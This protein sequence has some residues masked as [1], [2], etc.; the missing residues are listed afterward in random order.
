MS[1]IPDGSEVTMPL[2]PRGPLPFLKR[3]PSRIERIFP[4]GARRS[5]VPQLPSSPVVAQVAAGDGALVPQAPSAPSVTHTGIATERELPRV[6]RSVWGPTVE[7]VKVARP[8]VPVV[9]LAPPPATVTPAAGSAVPDPGRTPRYWVTV[10]VN[11]VPGATVE[12]T[13]P[14]TIGNTVGLKLASEKSTSIRSSSP[15][16]S[17][18]LQMPL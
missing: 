17:A 3:C 6:A 7:R 2:S 1:P 18:S 10:T 13:P 11:A 12:G 5:L 15:S 4:R 9:A 16:L 8:S 14:R